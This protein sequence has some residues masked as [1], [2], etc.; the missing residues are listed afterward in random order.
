MR[1]KITFKPTG[2]LLLFLFGIISTQIFINARLHREI[3]A[4][5]ELASKHFREATVHQ[6]NLVE[7][8]FKLKLLRSPK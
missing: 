1:W 4:L 3:N 2:Y 6:R 7:C 8:E 5:A